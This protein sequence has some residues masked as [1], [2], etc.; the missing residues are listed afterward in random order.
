[1][2]FYHWFSSHPNE[3]DLSGDIRK[4]QDIAKELRITDAKKAERP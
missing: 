1:M 3:I 4:M 2:S